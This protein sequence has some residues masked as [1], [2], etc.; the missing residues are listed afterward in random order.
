MIVQDADG[1]EKFGIAPD[2]W[3]KIEVISQMMFGASCGIINAFGSFLWGK[4]SQ[5][6]PCGFIQNTLS[7]K[8]ACKTCHASNLQNPELIASKTIVFKCHAGLTQFVIR[9]SDQSA[10][11]GPGVPC[12]ALNRSVIDIISDQLG[13]D[14]LDFGH[15]CLTH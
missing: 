11:L 8:K 6:Q 14:K 12:H 2:D 5:T 15:F 7:G 1:I 4:A 10:I 13:F 9:L 3:K